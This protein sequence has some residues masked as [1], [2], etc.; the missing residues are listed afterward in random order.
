MVC[1]FLCFFDAFV[2]LV[3]FLCRVFLFLCF[4]V[5]FAVLFGLCVEWWVFMGLSLGFDVLCFVSERF[6]VCFGWV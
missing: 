5:L 3:W 6:G 2:L 1:F 4:G